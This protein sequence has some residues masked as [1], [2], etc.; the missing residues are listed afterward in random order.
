[1]LSGS[2]TELNY[3]P[4]SSALAISPTQPNSTEFRQMYSAE[5]RK[6]GIWVQ[7]EYNLHRFPGGGGYSGI[8][9]DSYYL[10]GGYL[11]GKFLPFVRYESLVTNQNLS[12]NPNFYQRQWAVGTN[13]AVTSR[14][15]LRMEADRNHG[16]A[17]P[18]AS[19]G[20]PYYVA[21]TPVPAGSALP[22]LDWNEFA[23]ELNFSF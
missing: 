2:A 19:Q 6:D 23:V 22:A 4:I 11:M 9:S 18:I 13:Y 14:V 1:M 21:A 12:S 16:Y 8:D 10:Q 20:S 17:L 5:Y 7:S 3:A 15:N